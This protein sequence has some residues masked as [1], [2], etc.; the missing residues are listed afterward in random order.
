ML[1]LPER[2]RVVPSVVRPLCRWFRVLRRRPVYRSF[3]LH[4]IARHARRRHARQLVTARE[5]AFAAARRP[6]EL[7]QAV[8]DGGAACRD[9]PGDTT[10]GDVP[11]R[12]LASADRS[13]YP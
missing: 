5:Q 11:L 3:V 8:G 10:R 13:S 7:A 2:L 12:G 1:E 4:L 9:V 6:Q